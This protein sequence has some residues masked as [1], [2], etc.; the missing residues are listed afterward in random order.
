VVTTERR[1]KDKVYRSHL[2][3][4]SYRDGGKVKK[5]TVANLTALGD[6]VVGLIRDA[7]RGHQLGRLDDA[8]EVTRSRRHGDVQAVRTAM[9]RLGFDQL[10][11]TRPSPKRELVVAMI[12]ARILDP[13]SKLATTRNLS[14]TTL[15]EVLGLEDVNEDD[16]Y[17]AMDWL[18]ACQ[19]RIEKKLAARHLRED[20]L[21]LYDLSSS[22]F[23]G[24]TC[25]L[26]A[27]GHNRD[28]KKGTLQVNYGLL[29]DDRGCPV[30]VSVFA[31]NTSD[32]KTL[33]PQIT[34]VRED[35]GI[36]RF[37]IAGD[38]GMITQK[39][40]DALRD[41]E[42]ID[43]ITAL[44]SDA[45][46]KL[47]NA[48]AVQMGLFDERG[49]FELTHPDFPGERL[50]AC[51]N[52]DLARRRA[53]K[54]QSL[55]DATTAELQKVQRMVQRGRLREA[56]KI[57]VR[58]G[59]VVNKYK[60]AKHFTLT[61]DDDSFHF[62]LK[63]DAIEA[64]AA[65]DGIYV[66]RTSLPRD[67]IDTDDIVRNYKRLTQVERAFR[68][69]KTMDLHVRPIHHHLERR[70]RAHIF[71]CMLAYYVRWH[72]AEAWRPLLFADEDQAAKAR[73]DPVAAARRSDT[74][75]HKVCTQR[76]NHGV[77]VHSFRTLLAAL[78]TVVR[79]TCRRRG[80]SL[81]EATF[82]LDTVPTATQKL[83]LDLLKDIS[84]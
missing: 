56:D 71:L 7:L 9:K 54:R 27:L 31:G 70:V 62:E 3:R 10:I 20:G 32:P 23:E 19:S 51:R 77:P 82:H 39:Q 64:E 66:V 11:G 4:R 50:V 30:A 17:E 34:K 79:N 83:A 6:E 38:R 14:S 48:G 49:L 44:R 67:R 33:L 42:G 13:Q 81:D 35:F 22:Y 16:L 36:A 5:E 65:L 29:T 21:A 26:A 75:M 60:V 8:F 69:F 37:A 41:I 1:Y 15:P 74:A 40:I 68:S 52:P 18:L 25:P 47:A 24:H 2:L 12:A 28:G 63:R 72:M 58:V 53:G 43:W 55:L 57:G 45:I 73:R 84:L 78:G 80:A 76:T 61:I 59:K 46:R